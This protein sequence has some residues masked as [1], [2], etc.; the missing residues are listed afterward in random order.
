MTIMNMILRLAAFDLFHTEKI[1]NGI[2]HF[3]QTSSL[4]QIFEDSGYIGS[5]FIIGIGPMFIMMVMYFIYL[6]IRGLVLKSC[7]EQKTFQQDRISQFMSKILTSFRDHSVETTCI[8]FI[9]EGTIEISLWGFICLLYI[10]KNGVGMPYFSE[11]FSNI[12]SFVS[13]VPLSIAPLY[14]LYRA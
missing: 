13:L 6:A 8:S 1:L 11:V 10:R 3:K 9:L 5:N 2:F 12:F 4:S 7:S 14:L